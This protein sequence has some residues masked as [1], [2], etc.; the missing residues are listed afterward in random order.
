M[1][2]SNDASLAALKKR[3]TADYGFT[4]VLR[5]E[6]K[7][8]DL[9]TLASQDD[10]DTLMQTLVAAGDDDVFVN[11]II[12]ESQSLPNL[13]ASGAGGG[14]YNRVISSSGSFRPPP[15]SPK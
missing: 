7:E 9:I 4:V 13:G 10:F 11:V 14:M 15:A 1:V 3:L 12:T 2:I 6:D 5:Y 8:G